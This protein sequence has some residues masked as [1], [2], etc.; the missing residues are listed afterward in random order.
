ML[1]EWLGE[2]G[3]GTATELADRLPISRQ[4]VT[5]HL[6]QLESAGVIDGVKR[7][8]EVR[9]ELKPDR[10]VVTADWLRDR[11]DRWQETLNRLAEYLA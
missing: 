3:G 6:K 11:A 1:V 10:L 7:G 9:Y 2:G 4:A 5:R 8:R